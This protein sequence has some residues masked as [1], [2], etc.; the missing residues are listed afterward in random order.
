MLFI[1]GYATETLRLPEGP[2]TV[3]PMPLMNVI[4]GSDS[5][6][7]RTFAGSFEIP[8][9]PIGARFFSFHYITFCAASVILC[10]R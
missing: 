8:E 10:S 2:Y 5:S 9:V 1:V 6:P 3:E 7:Y 4:A